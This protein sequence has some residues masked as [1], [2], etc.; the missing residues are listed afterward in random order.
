[1]YMYNAIYL[2][3]AGKNKPYKIPRFAS[4]FQDFYL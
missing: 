4:E 2:A 1:M 3:Y